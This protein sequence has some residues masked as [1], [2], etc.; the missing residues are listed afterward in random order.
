MKEFFSQLNLNMDGLR[1]V[2]TAIK[3]GN[4]NL[5]RKM[6]IS[7]LYCRFRKMGPKYLKLQDDKVDLKE[8]DDACKN[9]FLLTAHMHIKHNFGRRINWKTIL[10]KDIESNVSLNWHTFLIT[11][12][13]AYNKTG[14]KKYLRHAIRLFNSWY[15]DSPVPADSEFRWCE[16]FQ[17]RTLEVGG[18]LC[19][20][21]PEFMF[22]LLK[23]REFREKCLFNMAR[24]CLDHAHYLM[25]HHAVG[26]NWLQVESSGLGICALLFPEF[27]ESGKFLKTAMQ[28]LKWVNSKYVLPDGFQ[29]ECSTTY[30]DFPLSA[31]CS[32]CKIAQ[33]AK[34]NLPH[35]L[36]K[37]IER[38]IEVEMY[39]A[40]PDLMMPLLS[41]CSPR[42]TSILPTMKYGADI[43]G[44][45]NFRYF[46]TNRKK[47]RPPAK[48]SYAFPHS[49][50]CVMREN[51]DKDAQYL[52]FD[53]GYFGSG[54]QHEDKLNFVLCAYGR[55]LIIDP[56]IYRYYPDE[57]SRYF[58]STQAH[59]SVLVDGKGQCRRTLKERERIPDPDAKWVSTPD[60]DLA[61]GA[62]KDGFE[63]LDKNIKH[64]RSILYL[65]GQ[66]FITKDTI[67]GKGMHMIEQKFHLSPVIKRTGKIS[68]GKV[69]VDKNGIVRTIEP[70]LANIAIVPLDRKKVKVNIQRGCRNPVA[71][72]VAMDGM[73]PSHEITFIRRGELPMTF[74]TILAPLH[75][76]RKNV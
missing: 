42:Y 6:Y 30:H 2:K 52:V 1:K 17:W 60:Y 65:K 57:Y 76:G 23:S 74:T 56:S 10:N 13:R 15:E 34:K 37:L 67:Y 19:L 66:C 20:R 26:G 43:F 50:Y 62:Y 48:C 53:A 38:M 68:P 49:G 54:H 39:I 21:W 75:P 18:R 12:A 24:S 64:K 33:L 69:K 36:T 28:R 31:M 70:G 32:L 73:Q 27:N 51:W 46:A 8:A 22:R 45:A 47:G 58:R 59:N 5:A 4:Y 7:Y 25:S 3:M 35:G 11:L 40:Q 44:R 63:G 61:T 9:I 72:W 14:N 29:S 55:P 41:D 16:G 71:G